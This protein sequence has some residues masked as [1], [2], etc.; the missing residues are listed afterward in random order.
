M[1][2]EPSNPRA[3]AGMTACGSPDKETYE[4]ET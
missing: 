2:Y 4:T 3:A 1:V